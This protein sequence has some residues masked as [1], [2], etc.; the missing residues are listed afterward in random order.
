MNIFTQQSVSP[1]LEANL[2]PDE[3]FKKHGAGSS[4]ADI[5]KRWIDSNAPMRMCVYA[6]TQPHLQE[7]LSEEDIIKGANALLRRQALE[8]RGGKVRLDRYF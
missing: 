7:L 2:I 4:G 3:L 6:V 1:L 5:L 8:S